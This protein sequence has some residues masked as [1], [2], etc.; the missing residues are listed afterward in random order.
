MNKRAMLFA[1]ALGLTCAVCTLGRQ[2]RSVATISGTV[3]DVT[4]AAVAG[5]E[6]D[7]KSEECVCSKC[8]HACDCCPD[9]HTTSNDTGSFTFSVGHGVYRLRLSKAGF[10]AKEVTVDLKNDGTKSVSVKMTA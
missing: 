3:T 7:L 10:H 1:L 8:P 5:V 4:G 9:Q 6:I 2:E